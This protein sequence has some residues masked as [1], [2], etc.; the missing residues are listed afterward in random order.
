MLHQTSGF[1]S[2]GICRKHSAFQCVRAMKHRQ[3]I[4]MLVWNRCG[5]DKKRVGTRY[6]KLLFLRLLGSAGHVVHSRASGVQNVYALVF[7]LGS[8]RCGF[9]KKCAEPRYARLCFCMQWDL[10]VS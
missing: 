4:F 3:A 7:M 5:F 1:A 10:W 9:H 2:G 8:V 6:A